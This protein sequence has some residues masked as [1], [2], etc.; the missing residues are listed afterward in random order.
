MVAVLSEQHKAI[1]V[2]RKLRTK[3]PSHKL[4]EH[5]GIGSRTIRRIIKN[6]R[7]GVFNHGRDGRPPCFDDESRHAIRDWL[8]TLVHE[9]GALEDT[10]LIAKLKE[11]AF[12]TFIRRHP[13][14]I[15]KD[16]RR[17]NFIS[18]RSLKTY[19]KKY[20]IFFEEIPPTLLT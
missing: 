5:F 15:N 4:S 20:R 16:R 13:G 11:E 18:Y 1:I 9:S 6:A 3:L 10:T 8:L 19:Q 7:D 17:K 2:D 14:F 12:K